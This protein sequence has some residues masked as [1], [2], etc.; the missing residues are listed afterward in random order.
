LVNLFLGP[1]EAIRA[2]L[3]VETRMDVIMS[4]TT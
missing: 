3:N 4:F 2:P 1:V